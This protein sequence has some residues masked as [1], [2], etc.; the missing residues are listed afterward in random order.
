MV[1][2]GKR[3][4]SSVQVESELAISENFETEFYIT[5]PRFNPNHLIC[6]WSRHFHVHLKKW[7]CSYTWTA[8]C[9]WKKQKEILPCGRSKTGW[10]FAFCMFFDQHHILLLVAPQYC[11]HYYY[12]EQQNLPWHQES[13]LERVCSSINILHLFFCSPFWINIL[14][15]R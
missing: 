9:N 2:R 14:T 6:S 13:F 11:L 5:G 7:D 15:F 3:S 1:I 4:H 10:N 12:V 8:P